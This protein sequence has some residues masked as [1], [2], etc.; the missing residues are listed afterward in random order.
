[1]KNILKETIL[2]ITF[3]SIVIGFILGMCT[4]AELLSRVITMNMIMTV[5]YIVMGYGFIYIFK[6]L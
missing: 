4:I 1:M 5:I 3:W 2:G 6:N